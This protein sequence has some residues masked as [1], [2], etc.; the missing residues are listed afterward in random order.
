ML[1]FIVY[2]FTEAM[3]DRIDLNQV[4]SEEALRLIDAQCNDPISYDNDIYND[5]YNDQ[6]I[7]TEEGIFE[8]L[9]QYG[10]DTDQV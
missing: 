1:D 2:G 10:L 6:Y 8:V 7:E 4:T 3:L 9:Q 5:S